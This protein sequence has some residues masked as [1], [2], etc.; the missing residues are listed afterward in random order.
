MD[1]NKFFSF[2]IDCDRKP[3]DMSVDTDHDDDDESTI[4]SLE[5]EDI[6]IEDYLELVSKYDKLDDKFN[7][8]NELMDNTKELMAENTLKYNML[9]DSQNVIITSN[10]SQIDN[11]KKQ[12]DKLL[13]T[14]DK[15][16]KNKK[17]NSDYYK[18]HDKIVEKNNNILI[19]NISLKYKDR[20]LDL[21]KENKKLFLKCTDLEKENGTIFLKYKNVIIEYIHLENRLNILLYNNVLKELKD[22]LKDKITYRNLFKKVLDELILTYEYIIIS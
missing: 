13:D 3:S 5:S 8:L 6:N 12:I 10:M 21:E 22:V 19:N 9:I 4:N 20:I 18:Q 1:I 17:E 15:L 11:Y 14:I 7:K 16:E 2:L